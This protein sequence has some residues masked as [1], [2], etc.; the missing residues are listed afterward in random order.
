MLEPPY[1]SLV[2]VPT[3]FYVRDIS[4]CQT[5]SKY[6]KVNKILLRVTIVEVKQKKY[7]TQSRSVLLKKWKNSVTNFVNYK[8]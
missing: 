7:I 3:F 8:R 2:I 4:S 5:T 1:T 6:Q